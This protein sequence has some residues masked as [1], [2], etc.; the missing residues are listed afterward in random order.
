ML[1]SCSQLY[2]KFSFRDFTGKCLKLLS[3]MES[4]SVP[5]NEHPIHV[6]DEEDEEEDD[7]NAASGGAF[8]SHD[9]IDFNFLHNK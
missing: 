4:A 3:E 1:S 2:L 6:E 8:G 5:S 9:G 7:D